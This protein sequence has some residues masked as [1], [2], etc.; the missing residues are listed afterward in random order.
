MVSNPFSGPNFNDS[1]LS[2]SF[3]LCN[4]RK[5]CPLLINTGLQAGVR[6]ALIAIKPFQQLSHPRKASHSAQWTSAL[7]LSR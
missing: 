5:A 3:H 2:Y 4:L 6:P 7:M 1:K